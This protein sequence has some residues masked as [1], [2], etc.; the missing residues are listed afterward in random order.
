MED[1]LAA[2]RQEGLGIIVTEFL[3]GLCGDLRLANAGSVTLSVIL[4]FFSDFLVVASLQ[5]IDIFIIE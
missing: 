4:L 3:L 2:A 1:L 5:E